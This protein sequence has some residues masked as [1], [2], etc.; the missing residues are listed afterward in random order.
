MVTMRAESN[1]HLYRLD[2]D[3]LHGTAKHVF[4]SFKWWC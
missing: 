3:G 2:V 1:D 4:A